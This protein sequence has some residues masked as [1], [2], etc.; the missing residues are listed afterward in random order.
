MLCAVKSGKAEVS[1]RTGNAQ[2]AYLCPRK[3]YKNVYEL[4]NYRAYK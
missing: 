4:Y 3:G 1:P 2:F